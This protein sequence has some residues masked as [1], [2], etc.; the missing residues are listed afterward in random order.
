[1]TAGSTSGGPGN[2]TE[3]APD[4]RTGQLDTYLLTTG[5]TEE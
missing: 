1:M 3:I 2:T 4:H 5:E